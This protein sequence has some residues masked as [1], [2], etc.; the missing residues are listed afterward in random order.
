MLETLSCHLRRWCDSGARYQDT[1]WDPARVVNAVL[2][3]QGAW[4]V[5]EYRFRR[6]SATAP[7]LF[8]APLRV[9]GLLTLKLVETATGIS[10]AGRAD[11]GPG[12][13][14]GHFGGLVVGPD[15]RIG[16]NCNLSQGVTIGDHGGSPVVGDCVYFAPGAKVFGP[17]R[18]GDHV[19]IGANAVVGR[20]VPSFSTAVAGRPEILEGRG[21]MVPPL[22]R[23]A[24]WKS[25]ERALW[26]VCQRGRRRRRPRRGGCRLARVRQGGHRRQGRAR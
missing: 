2:T 7:R 1:E 26:R 20:S 13:Y 8:R 4:A 19:A 5:I 16:E 6:W 24:R 10:L 14:V 25:A 3:E 22:G 15:V 21:N 11:I 9:L 18:I 12:L 17:I 23:G